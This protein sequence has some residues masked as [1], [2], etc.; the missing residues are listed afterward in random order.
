YGGHYYKYRPYYRHGSSYYGGHNYK[1][2]PY[3]R[4]G[5]GHQYK[6]RHHGYYYGDAAV[7]LGVLA[8]AVVLG[9]LLSQ[10]SPAPAYAPAVPRNPSGAPL[11]NCLA[12]T[13]TGT[14]YGRPARFTGTMCYDPAGRAYVLPG[15]E[16]FLRYLR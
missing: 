8:G 2:R 9:A 11:G 16:R 4:Y 5:Y 10:P 14:W 12:T 13:G 15:S 6:R 3:Y 7:V 1:Y